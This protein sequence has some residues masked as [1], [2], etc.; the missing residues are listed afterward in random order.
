MSSD[1]SEAG[2]PIVVAAAVA[3]LAEARVDFGR[4]ASLWL[5]RK[6]DPVCR[7]GAG[8]HRKDTPARSEAQANARGR[9]IIFLLREFAGKVRLF[10]PRG[11]RSLVG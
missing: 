10:A 4:V 7:L 5:Q 1:G 6:V 8:G 11:V 2:R 3:V 9:F